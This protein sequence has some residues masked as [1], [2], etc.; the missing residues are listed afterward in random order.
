LAQPEVILHRQGFGRTSRKDFWW[1][2]PAMVFIML[3][4]FIVYTTWAAFQ[5]EYYSFGNYL[6]PFYSP[7]IFG[8]SSHSWFGP[9]PEW[10]PL[11]LPF[12][13][14]FFIL[15]GPAGMRFTCYYYRG[16]YYKAFWADPPACAVGEPRKKYWGENKFPLLMQNI[17]RYFLYPAIFF[18]FML[19][20]DAWKALWFMDPA[21]GDSSFGIGVGSLV[22]LANAIL[23][24]A[25]TFGC[26][27]FRHLV[28]GF[29]NT[30]SKSSI[31]KTAYKC[32]SCLNKRHMNFAWFSLIWVA[33]A[34]VYVRL[35]AMGII[36]D[37]RI[38]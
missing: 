28:G 33:L 13:P 37:L 19:T 27:S 21:T 11:M 23:L 17:H 25:Y 8:A 22:L 20:Y 6:S 32:S 10:W 31:R 24:G 7:E 36:T 15:W 14:A 16:A 12:S 30:L 29:K 35:C 34:D 38:F 26:H 4:S 9:Q 1:I 5:G 18:V 3:F 2:Q